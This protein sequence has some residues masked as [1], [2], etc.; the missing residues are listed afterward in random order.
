LLEHL[1]KVLKD[2]GLEGYVHRMRHFFITNAMEQSD[3]LP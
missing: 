1:K 3:L 2:L